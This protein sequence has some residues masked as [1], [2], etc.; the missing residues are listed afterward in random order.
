LRGY[1]TLR[2]QRDALICALIF[3]LTYAPPGAGMLPE[4]CRDAAGILPEFGQGIAVTVDT[5]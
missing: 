5:T 4:C 2:A 3:A 1:R